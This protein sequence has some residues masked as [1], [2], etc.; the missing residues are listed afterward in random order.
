MA[1]KLVRTTVQPDTYISGLIGFLNGISV[2]LVERDKWG[3]GILHDAFGIG[4]DAAIYMARWPEARRAP[5][6]HRG[7]LLLD[8]KSD[9]EVFLGG[10]GYDFSRV[11]EPRKTEL[12]AFFAWRLSRPANRSYDW[13]VRAVRLIEFCAD[14]TGWP[15]L[16]IDFGHPVEHGDGNG[17]S[18]L[19][20]FMID[21]L[22]PAGYSTAADKQ[23]FLINGQREFDT[24][25]YDGAN[26]MPAN[27]LLFTLVLLREKIKPLAHRDIVLAND[28]FAED[29][30]PHD[31]R[32]ESY[33]NF[34]KIRLP[35]LREACRAFIL[36][37]IEYK[38][39]GYITATLHVSQFKR[40]EDC[41]F[42]SFSLPN[43]SHIT[44]EFVE[45]T[46]LAWGND[47]KFKG[48]NWYSGVVNIISWATNYLSS[49]GWPSLAFDKRI[50]RKVEGEWPGGRGY[51]LRVQERSIPEEVVEQIFEFIR[52]GELPALYKRLIILARYT[53]MRAGDLH[54][55]D[56]DCLKV[57][58]DDDRFLLLTFF[59]S[60]VKM[61]NT[62]PLL[63]EDAAHAL[64]I[65]AIREQQKYAR[66]TCGTKPRYLFGDRVG[67]TEKPLS[68]ASTRNLLG[69]WCRKHGIRDKNGKPFVFGWH[70]FRHFLGTELALLGHG[71]ALIQMELGHASPEMSMVYVNQRLRLQK[72]AVLEKG[73]GK[74]VDIQGRVD[75]K[76]A[77]LAVRKDASLTIDVA[78]GI[79]TMPAQ[80][81]EWC[82]HNRAC[83]TCSFFRADVSQVEFF[84]NE[85]RALTETIE[86]LRTETA[87]FET[88]GRARSAEIGRKRVER[89]EA[90][91]ASVNAVLI[92]IR[93]NGVYRGTTPNYKRAGGG[94]G[95]TECPRAPEDRGN[96]LPD[97]CR[98]G[99]HHVQND[100]GT[101]GGEPSVPL[102]AFQGHNRQTSNAAKSDRRRRRDGD[103][104][105]SRPVCDH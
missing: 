25:F 11:A 57:D 43:L 78:G 36:N 52:R 19:R 5:I 51:A 64:V 104:A 37:N 30:L 38:E 46:F 103:R 49:Q 55:L 90:A 24:R 81:G 77:E 8:G 87:E 27:D 9:P 85:K 82:E 89:S 74:F 97:E 41:L 53:G 65:D 42:E 50:L 94:G 86:R 4:P 22:R 21:W 45:H 34:Y 101:G 32:K 48:K 61:W 13:H 63:K 18:R 10:I 79:C 68:H 14:G 100:L 35:W 66:E 96:D 12:K 91:L 70:G 39:F 83:L 47:R 16:L 60:K 6:R 75:E 98:G 40:F 69:I 44:R 102:S 93:S 26:S 31:R 7:R 73:T 58:P 80:I 59:Q 23:K 92:S 17:S 54:S 56:H 33:I 105:L 3:F 15:P 99:G 67:D 84:E 20:P 2:S 88:T 76:I 72:K 28:V 29:E 95:G 1:L 62:K 71:I